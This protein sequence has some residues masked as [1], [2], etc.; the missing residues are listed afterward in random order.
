MKL[1][2]RSFFIS[3][4][5]VVRDFTTFKIILEREE[6]LTRDK[7]KVH[8]GRQSIELLLKN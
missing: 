5:G 2:T 3:V 6:G 4:F 7:I 8:T 1:V